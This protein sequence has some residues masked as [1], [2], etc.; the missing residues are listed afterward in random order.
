MEKIDFKKAFKHLYSPSAKQPQFVEVPELQFLAIDGQGDPNGPVFESAVG[1]MYSVA[2][3]VKFAR[4]KKGLEPDYSIGPLEGLWWTE[5]APGFDVEHRDEWFWTLLIWQPDFVTLL[6]VAT[7]VADLIPKKDNPDLA[8]VRLEK[9]AE[10]RSAQIMHIG[11]YSIEGPTIQRLHAFIADSG[12]RLRGKHHEIYLG[13]PR[14]TKPEALKTIIR[15]P[16]E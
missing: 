2:Y 15:Q 3:T 9:Y 12:L 6:D 14:R 13:D 8:K 4:K 7:A 5:G 10:G 16:A 11:P 1:A